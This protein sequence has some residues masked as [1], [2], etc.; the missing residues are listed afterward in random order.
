MP[1]SR[2]QWLAHHKRFVKESYYVIGK[3][4]HHSRKLLLQL[5]SKNR[6]NY[7][8]IY[9]VIEQMFYHSLALILRTL[10]CPVPWADFTL[11]PVQGYSSGQGD[12]GITIISFDLSFWQNQLFRGNYNDAINSKAIFDISVFKVSSSSDQLWKH[13]PPPPKQGPS[14]ASSSTSGT[15]LSVSLTALS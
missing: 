11:R 7:R 12:Y 8:E 4:Q 2:S 13:P 5:T 3:L 1:T 9:H 15:F 14:T 6:N 10:P